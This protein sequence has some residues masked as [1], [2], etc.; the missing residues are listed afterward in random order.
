MRGFFMTATASTARRMGFAAVSIS[1]AAGLTTA[2]SPASQASASHASA[3][4]ASASHASAIRASASVIRITGAAIARLMAARNAKGIP[5]PG[6]CL[7]ALPDP[8]CGGQISPYRYTRRSLTLKASRPVTGVSSSG[9]GGISGVVTN[10]RGRPVGGVCVLVDDENQDLTA[11]GADGEY[12]LAG[13][14]PGS[15][16]VQFFG[17]C[18]NTGSLA[19]QY[20]DNQPYSPF[21]KP[22]S[23]RPGAITHGI[24]AT[25]RAGGTI[26]GLVTD[27][28]GASL[29]GIC[30]SAATEGGLALPV[31][32]YGAALTQDGQFTVPNLAPGAYQVSFGCAGYGTEWFRSAPEAAAAETVAVNPGVT[33]SIGAQLSLAGT[34]SGTVT[35]AADQPLHHICVAL[36]P[37]GATYPFDAVIAATTSRSGTYSIGSLAPGR[38]LIQFSDC[39]SGSYGSQWYR[40]HPAQSSA[41]PVLV[42]AGQTDARVNAV[43]TEAGSIS[44]T[45]IGPSGQ[46]VDNA[47]VFAYSPATQSF[48]LSQTGKTG[49]Y[50]VSGLATGSYS[51]SFYPCSNYDQNLAEVTNQDLVDV[52]A[53]GRVTR[54]EIRPPAGG[55]VAG[56]VQAGQVPLDA[57]CV[58]LQPVSPD[59]SVGVTTTSSNGDYLV[60]NLA[61]GRYHAYIADPSCD[62][63]PDPVPPFPPQWY[64]ARRYQ[65]RRYQAR[66]YQARRYQARRYQAQPTQ[67]AATAIT[68]S[69]QATTHGIS[70]SLRPFGAITGTV[71]TTGDSPVSGECVTAVPYRAGLD[72]VT[73]IPVQPEVAVSGS[74]GSYSLIGLAPGRYRVEFSTGCGASGFARQWWDN[75]ASVKNA[76]IITVGF[77]KIS[78]INATLSAAPAK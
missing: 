34:I 36:T 61:P 72:P 37:A 62:G 7:S 49:Y 14:P 27:T 35:N 43:L 70:A 77:A 65:A 33:T 40:G 74:T 50:V 18:G 41:T 60:G 39:E 53:P 16:Q 44:G 5:F 64:Q 46:P 69:A 29:T 31:G 19:P 15:Y 48:A 10:S 21:A 20:Y 54:I 11:T 17:G 63:F 55:W 8:A 24:D 51:V 76:S 56:R 9:T 47:C 57:A 38:Y 73:D 32:D 42:T 58:L 67:A 52:T 45:V 23:F 26:A 25:M 1:L 78:G 3:S 4:P 30:V 68:V 75:Q 22:V 28:Q 2:L 59:G 66:R 71:A 12:T 6:A 13:V